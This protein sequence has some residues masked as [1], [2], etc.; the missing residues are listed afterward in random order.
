MEV[1]AQ[2][3]GFDRLAQLSKRLVSGVLHILLG[4]APQDGFGFRAMA[5]PT[6]SLGLERITEGTV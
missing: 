4:E 5:A 1:A 3:D 2:E 6:V